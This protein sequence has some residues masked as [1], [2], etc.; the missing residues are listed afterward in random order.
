MSFTGFKLELVV[1]WLQRKRGRKE[2][3]GLCY[4]IPWWQKMYLWHEDG[5]ELEGTREKERREKGEEGKERWGEAMTTRAPTEKKKRWFRLGTVAL[6]ENRR[7]QKTT[8]FLIRKLPFVQWVREIA[9]EQCSN[10]HFQATALLTLQ[11]ATE[12]YVVALFEDANQ[13]AIHAKWVTLMPKDIQ[14]AHRIRGIQLNISE[15]NKF[16]NK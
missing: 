6:R 16:N 10:L 12:A 8:G 2:E 11:E 3:N 13:C 5:E 1:I 15:A 14:L 4:W 9:Q 7:F